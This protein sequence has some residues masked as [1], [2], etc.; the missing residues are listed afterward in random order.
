MPNELIAYWRRFQLRPGELQVHPDDR[1]WMERYWPAALAQKPYAS[2]S[3]Y[4]ASGR[5]G[6]HDAQVHLSLLPVPFAGDLHQA[7]V[8]IFLANAGFM[9][10]DY[11]LHDQPAFQRAMLA[12]IHQTPA[13]ADPFSYLDPRFAWWEARLRPIVLALAEHGYP[14]RE[15]LQLLARKI[16]VVELFPYRSRDGS[17]LKGLSGPAPMPSVR[18]ARAYLAR[19]SG[20][21][22][23]L[24]LVMRKHALWH[25]P[26]S[27]ELAEGSLHY[28]HGP[29]LQ[30][31]SF[32]PKFPAGRSLLQRLLRD[33][34]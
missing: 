16:A 21:P 6:S 22:S 20:D 8:L 23:R 28:V 17:Q 27:A 33:R 12:E 4:Q 15:A 24:K 5:F 7:S 1:A 34:N 2:W 11:Y 9:A 32:D 30:G 3:E 19:V 25:A 14:Y 18:Q 26:A 10:A 13:R 29:R 31:V